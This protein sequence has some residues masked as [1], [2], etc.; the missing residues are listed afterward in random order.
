MKKWQVT[1]PIIGSFYF[2]GDFEIVEVTFSENRTNKEYE[3]KMIIEAENKK[4]AIKKAQ[5]NIENVL[6][7]ISF[8]REVGFD[9]G[10]PSVFQKYS[11]EMVQVGR[12]EETPGIT[13][14]HKKIIKRVYENLEPIFKDKENLS[15]ELKRAL[16]ALRWY[17]HGCF[18]SNPTD[19][20]L[21][22]WIAVESLAGE[23]SKSKQ[24]LPF[25][26]KDCID[27]IKK[28]LV[29]NDNLRSQVIKSIHE[30]YRP[31]PDVI[32]ENIQNILKVVDNNKIK[33]IKAKIRKMQE[34]RSGIVHKGNVQIDVA[35]HNEYLKQLMEKLLREKLDTAFDCFIN[36]WPT[37]ELRENLSEDYLEIEAIKCVLSMHPRGATIDE[38]EY[39][40][41]SLTKRIR[42]PKVLHAKIEV[43]NRNGGDI[44]TCK[45]NNEERY[46]LIS[47]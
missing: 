12:I 35:A 47:G 22:F 45:I 20:F 31:I 38:I 26:V 46:F 34:D 39:G 18:F 40:L 6:D 7:V 25:D 4:N 43:L 36:S 33:E 10:C 1:F 9:I 21:A 32:T 42:R 13:K 28:K 23:K 30:V 29:E 19:K 2:S 16:L 27:C 5:E 44:R 14:V 3:A 11:K 8:V 24:D 41:F 37:A 15:D 17:R